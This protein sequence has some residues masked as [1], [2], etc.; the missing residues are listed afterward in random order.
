MLSIYIAC[1]IFGG[2]LLLISAFSGG[3]THADMD[4]SLDVHTDM[5]HSLDVH[6][7]IDHSLDMHTDV[8]SSVD[9]E[10]DLAHDA[11]VADATESAVTGLHGGDT[12]PAL[13][14]DG[15]NVPDHAAAVESVKFLSFRN[16][17]FFTTFFGMTGTALDLMAVH[18]FITGL[19]AIGMGFFA[20]NIGYRL[21]RYLKATESGSALH[22]EELRGRLAT[23]TIDITASARGKIKLDSAGQVHQFVAQA[24]EEASR[25]EFRAGER[26]IISRFLQGIAHVIESDDL[27]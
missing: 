9:A 21:M 2:V 3:D 16:F 27:I 20:A 23:V 10:T 1:L 4:H 14:T 18:A 26:V 5:D 11:S 12:V 15:G 17:V 7:D 24:A 6:T 25:K 22:Q 8:D 19:S 13:H